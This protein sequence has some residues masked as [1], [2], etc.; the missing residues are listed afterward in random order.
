MTPRRF[1][2]LTV[3]ASVALAG[4]AMG[5]GQVASVASVSGAVEVQRGG[6]GEWQPTFPGNPLFGGEQ[7]RTDASG[8]ATLVFNDDCVVILAPSTTLTIDRYGGKPRRALLRLQDGA[9][10]A[11]VSGYGG[12]AARFEVETASAVVRVQS[13]RFVVRFDPANKATDVAAVEGT[14][15]VSGRTG[16]IGPGVEVGAGQTSRVELGKFPS[17]PREMTAADHAQ[18]MAGLGLFGTGGRDG[19]ANDNA[20]LDGRAVAESD[21]PQIT[22]AAAAAGNTYLNPPVPDEP[23]IWRL[24]PDVR[25]NTQS[26]PVYEAVPPNQVPPQQ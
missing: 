9:L 7:V 4:V 14:V 10:E 3:L 18:L 1:L 20:L 16:L 12:E 11:I 24:S 23:L 8:G 21:R 13:T 22:A 2:L 17:P 5:Q 26:L 19:L 6:K 25:A 15:A